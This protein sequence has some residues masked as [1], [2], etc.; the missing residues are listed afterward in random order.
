MQTD[1]GS[2]TLQLLSATAADSGWYQ[3]TAQNSVGSTAT[4]ARIHVL[5]EA[6]APTQQNVPHFPKPVK[7]IEPE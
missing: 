6:K 1:G 4:R 7:F 5:A 2:S 3:C